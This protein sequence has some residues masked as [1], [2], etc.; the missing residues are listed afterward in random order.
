MASFTKTP[1]TALLAL[2]SVAASSVVISSA[3]DVSGKIGALI[4]ARFG[5]RSATAAGAGIN[6]RIESSKATSGDNSWFPIATL[7]SGFG[8]CEAEAVNGTVSSGTN[9]IT[10]ASTTNLAA[11]D[12]IFIDNGTIANSEWGR[13]KSVV[14]NTSVTIEDNLVN[15]QTGSTLYDTAEIYAPIE[16]PSGCVRIRVVDD[17]SLF[18]QAH[19]IEVNLITVDSFT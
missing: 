11:G 2:Q 8:A 6:L 17:A 10:V 19:A 16:I 3:F 4:Q 5:R 1:Q 7:T 18:T 13:I 12:L 15:A 14:N 9:V